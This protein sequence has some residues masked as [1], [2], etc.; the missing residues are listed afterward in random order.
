M[1]N[2]E[3]C[4]LIAEDEPYTRDVLVH[5]IPWQ[6]LGITQVLEAGNGQ[7]ALELALAHR[8]DIVLSDIRMPKLNGIELAKEIRKEDKNCRFIFLS[9]Y[10]DREYLKSA[11]Q[12]RVVSYVEKPVNIPEIR[13]AAETAVSEILAQREFLNMRRRQHS[14]SGF[15]G[16]EGTAGSAAS[17][18]SATSADSAPAPDTRDENFDVEFFFIK[19]PSLENAP[20]INKAIDRILKNYSDEKLSIS[21]LAGQLY[22]SSNYLSGIFKKETGRTINQFITQVRIYHAK[23]YLKNSS[24][25]LNA[26]AL[27]TGY[28]DA[29]YFSKAFKRETGITPKAFRENLP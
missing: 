26:I 12:I 18:N 20:Y 15:S 5:Y 29:N 7:A 24:L 10:T 25:S 13:Q 8:P 19:N 1:E 14:E 11:I 3:I 9:A 28:H 27:R 21:Q 6:E 22:L 2:Q 17:A 23:Q 16:S 4:L